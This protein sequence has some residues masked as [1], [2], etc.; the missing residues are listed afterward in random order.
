MKKIPFYIVDVFA[1]KKYQ[2]NQLAVF[3]NAETLSQQEMQT[4]TKEINFQESTFVLGNTPTDKGFKVKIFTPEYE[5][6]FAGHPTIGTATVIKEIL[7]GGKAEKL[8]LDLQV[9]TIPVEFVPQADQSEIAW[10][11]AR[12]PAFSKHYDKDELARL[13]SIG[14]NDIEENY[15][16]EVVST[17]IGFM[18][19][20]LK[21]LQAVKQV[22]VDLEG[23]E[24][25][26]LKNQ[27]HKDNSP[28][29]IH[30]MLFIF[31]R[32]TY[33]PENQIN[34]RML[35]PE[36]GI[37]REDAATGSAN[38]C[39]LAYL[40]KNNFLQSKDLDISVEQGYEIARP[41]KLYLKGKLD[42]KDAYL[43]KVGGKIQ[44]VA[45]GAWTV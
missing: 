6:P 23:Y 3:F 24:N 9:G 30:T 8:D 29:G 40:L 22:K 1:E 5:M 15:P 43:L 26:L 21:S 41:S 36:N 32:E 4:I 10:L 28:T 14:K 27:L 39:L 12:P 2:G 13:L 38:S 33:F 42:E 11:T 31:S 7:L 37:V 44:W 16:I 20:P 18:M 34:A 35:L 19:V 45:N 25:F 17:G